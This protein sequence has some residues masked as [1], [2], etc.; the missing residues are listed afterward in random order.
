MCLSILSS[1][2]CLLGLLIK[3]VPNNC[4]PSNNSTSQDTNAATKSNDTEV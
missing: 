3:L 2:A 4:S 1:E